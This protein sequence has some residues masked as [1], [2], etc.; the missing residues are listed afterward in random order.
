M[1]KR[2]KDAKIPKIKTI[3]T[4]L[5]LYKS[6]TDEN[7][8]KLTTNAIKNTKEK[9]FTLVLLLYDCWLYHSLQN[10]FNLTLMFFENMANEMIMSKAIN[11]GRILIK[12][13]EYNLKALTRL[14]FIISKKSKLT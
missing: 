8:K 5:N 7:E 1:I 6:P 14:I 9:I 13:F 3:N 4:I 12:N 11:N 10:S 2:D